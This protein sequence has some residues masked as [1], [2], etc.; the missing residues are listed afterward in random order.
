[1]VATTDPVVVTL[2]APELVALL[3]PQATNVTT[4]R[5]PVARRLI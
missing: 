1:V 4:M 2:D 5:R 3:H